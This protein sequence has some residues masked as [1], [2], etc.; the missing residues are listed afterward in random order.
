MGSY[1]LQPHLKKI[2]SLLAVSTL[3]QCVIKLQT[4]HLLTMQTVVFALT[5]N[6]DNSFLVIL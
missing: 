5:E 3:G 1:L 2:I 4:L 6:I